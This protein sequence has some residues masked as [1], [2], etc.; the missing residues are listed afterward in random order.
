M[1]EEDQVIFQHCQEDFISFGYAMDPRY[2]Y[3]SHIEII[4]SALERTLHEKNLRIIIEAP[5]RHSK[6]YNVS[7]RFPAW[8]IGNRPSNYLITACYGQD[9]ASDFGTK[10]K[11]MVDDSIYQAIFPGV[12]LAKDSKSKK[13]FNTS[14][15]GTYFAVGRGGAIT[16]RGG[17][18]II[19]DD[20]IKD[21]KE[22]RSDL[23]KKNCVEWYKNTLYTRLM[24]GGSIIVMATRWAEDDLIGYLLDKD[25]EDWERI[26]LPAISEDGKALW[27]EKYPVERLLTIKKVMGTRNFE[28]LYQQNPT[29]AEGSI[30]KRQWLKFYNKLPKETLGQMDQVILSW[31]MAFKG[32]DDS[33]YVVGSVYARYKGNFY[34][35]DKI[36]EKLDF[37]NTIKAF[38]SLTNQYPM[39]KVKLVE[40]K[41]NGPA[42]IAM[43][44]D[45]IP[46]IVEIEPTTSKESRVNSVAPLY[47]S[48]NVYYPDK[49]IA[50]WIDEHVEEVV[51]FPLAKNDDSVDAESQALE[52]LYEGCADMEIYDNIN[53]YILT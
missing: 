4:A 47:E 18:V 10:V 29:P 26:R 39:A 16:G 40:D 42:V 34:L 17:D 7:E 41:A 25:P 9:L 32:H 37:P 13:K 46:G 1:T 5:P 43:L 15:K 14:K 49:E 23:I 11:N 45:K 2:S 33:D 38:I 28:A 31:D 20:L 51:G 6:S 12:E 44:R 21:D 30:I 36:R 22:A 8:Y 48:G 35:I 52:Y 19:I 50:P 53:E 27:P 24:P 3:S